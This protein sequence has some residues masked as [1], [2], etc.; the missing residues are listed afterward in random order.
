[1]DLQSLTD[2]ELATFLELFRKAA[3]EGTNRFFL[4]LLVIVERETIKRHRSREMQDYQDRELVHAIECLTQLVDVLRAEGLEDDSGALKFVL[5]A[6]T[7]AIVEMERR[8]EDKK[9]RVDNLSFPASATVGAKGK[10][11]SGPIVVFMRCALPKTAILS[12]QIITDVPRL[13]AARGQRFQ[14]I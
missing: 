7:G 3:I 4:D 11:L 13:H 8:K 10:S 12:G 9:K 1:M 14:R 6:S 2:E 5:L